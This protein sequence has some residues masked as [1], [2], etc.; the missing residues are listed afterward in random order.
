[1]SWR[2]V[3]SPPLTG[4]ENMAIDEAIMNAVRE[5]RVPPTVRLYSWHLPTLSIGAFQRIEREVNVERCKELGVDIVR[6]PTGGRA[7]LHEAEVTYSFIVREDHPLIPPGVRESYQVAASAIVEGL[8]DMGVPAEI[9][10]REDGQRDRHARPGTGHAPACFDSPSWY[11][12]TVNGKKLV[13]S[14]QRRENGV[15]LQHGS[16]LLDFD[17]EKLMSVLKFS[18]EERKAASQRSLV[19]NT[20]TVSRVL[21]RQVGFDET[22]AALVV[23]FSRRLNQQLVPEDLTEFEISLAQQLAKEKYSSSEWLNRK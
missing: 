17:V 7:V 6:R 20:E 22:A 16:I 5:E 10:S 13:G 23:G 2:L 4:A 8:V 14:A 15:L 1:M 19:D 21:G 11:E 9:Y 12:I 3:V 18:S